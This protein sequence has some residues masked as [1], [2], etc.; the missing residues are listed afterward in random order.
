MSV[1]KRKKKDSSAP[2]P[3]TLKL[4][5]STLPNLLA[6]DVV[7]GG[8]DGGGEDR[9][10]DLGGRKELF[11]AFLMEKGVTPGSSWEKELIKFCFDAR[12]KSLLPEMS[13]RRA[14]FFGLNRAD[15]AKAHEQNRKAGLGG[16]KAAAAAGIKVR[17]EKRVRIL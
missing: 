6:A 10:A 1:I 16:K 8:E 2:A 13:D 15:A 17:P 4:S 7:G 11:K 3:Q 9:G 14:V 12:Y 5:P